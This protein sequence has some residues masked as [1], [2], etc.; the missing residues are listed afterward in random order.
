ML[1]VLVCLWIGGKE[2]FF[3]GTCC[4]PRSLNTRR[5]NYIFYVFFRQVH[6]KYVNPKRK[7]K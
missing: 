1:L 5:S 7:S 4:S 2:T 3:L 6:P